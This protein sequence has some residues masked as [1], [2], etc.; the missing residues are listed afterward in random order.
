MLLLMFV[1]VRMSGLMLFYYLFSSLF[2]VREVAPPDGAEFG[3][4][5]SI[6]CN[7]N[8]FRKHLLP[9]FSIWYKLKH[10]PKKI[11]VVDFLC[12]VT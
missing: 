12:F 3:K 9:W 8:H 7:L 1:I 6:G 4:I 5:I 11:A 2:Q 10:F